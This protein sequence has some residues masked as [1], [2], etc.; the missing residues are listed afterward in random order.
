[1]IAS[2]RPLLFVSTLLALTL[3]TQSPALIT[4]DP[5]KPLHPVSPD[6]YGI[7]FEEINNAG[8]GGLYAEMVRN[9]R[10]DDAKSPVHWVAVDGASMGLN[11]FRGSGS[12]NLW[13][14][15]EQNSG[16]IN[17]GYWGINLKA[18]E[19]YDATISADGGVKV[20][21]SLE[22]ADGTVLARETTAFT[23]EVSTRK[24][25][26]VPNRSTSQG[27]LTIRLQEA[28]KTLGLFDVSLFPRNTWKQRPN[29][30]R[31][32]LAEMLDA[33]NPAFVRFPGGCWV[34]GDT[35]ATSLRWKQTIGPLN[36]RR[37]QANLWNYASG[38]GLGYHEY[39]QLC[40]DLGSKALFVIN[41]GMAHKDVIPMDQMDEFVQD[42][43]DAVEYANGPATS[44]WGRVRAANGHPK[45]F[46]LRYLEIGN[47]NGGPE[48]AK[49]YPLFV[50]ALSAKHP[51]VK[52]ITNVWGGVPNTAKVDIIDEHYYS[53]AEFFLQNESRYDSYDRKGP[54]VY[55]GEYA[56]TQG[57]TGGITAAIGEAAFMVGME[58]N[59]DIVTMSSYAPLFAHV[60]N[61]VWNPDLIYFDNNRVYGTPS[62]YV[63][64]LFS[65][66]RPDHIVRTTLTG[67]EG[68]RGTFPAGG[69]GVGTWATQAEFKE[70]ELQKDG[71]A[72][73]SSSDGRGLKVSGGKWEAIDGAVRQT[74][75][76]TPA[77]AWLDDPSL[78]NYS[79]K[80]KARKV[81]GD[82][83]FLISVGRKDADNYLWW[84][85]GGWGN[86][87]HAIEFA[88]KGSKS[89]V[90]RQVPGKVETGRWY[91]IEIVYS[92]ERIVCKLDGKTV[93][94]EAYPVQK[95]MFAVSGT[96]KGGETI[97]KVV[98]A[99]ES[100]KKI[101]LEVGKVNATATV[102]V[103]MSADTSVRNSLD[104]PRKVYPRGTTQRFVDGRASRT[105]PGN[106]VTVIRI[107]KSQ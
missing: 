69:I 106:S 41:C 2:K 3:A 107:P 65:M 29:G 36:T 93:F 104:E 101:Q 34:E 100:A 68:P 11:T 6:L 103:L 28:D 25:S 90:G 60:N 40:E 84:N 92:P 52:L 51:E 99:G 17:K 22:D 83:G 27:A 74:T 13:V 20:S 37:T 62:Y 55:V 88:R 50:K 89:I 43:L 75:R 24:V 31:P 58:R 81:G 91:D 39:L 76:E 7:F 67:M 42:A 80:L 23:S 15:G 73:Y 77:T 82:E 30:L 95:T 45:P 59:S 32:D 96:T 12:N 9:G 48:Y 14:K 21:V 61:V 46:N 57:E 26:L 105:F 87:K 18:G 85:I 5:S 86:T 53:N 10:F 70:I 1:M 66:N 16:V 35:C 49:R 71:R 64:Q 79:L 4:V 72:V 8:D 33:L 44:K 38:N 63:Q 94:E 56:V 98:N 97:L 47:E 78:E 54:K 19:T 102:Q